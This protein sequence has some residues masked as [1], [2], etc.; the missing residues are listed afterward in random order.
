L[1]QDIDFSRIDE[2]NPKL[3][4]SKPNKEIVSTLQ[5]AYNISIHPKLGS[6]SE[7]TFSIPVQTEI[8]HE[9]VKNPDFEL[10]R[11]FY[12]VKYV[13]GDT[14]EW[15]LLD[16]PSNKADDSTLDRNIHCYSLPF[17]LSFRLLN[18]YESIAH[19]AEVVLTEILADTSWSINYI[20]SSFVNSYRTITADN[21]SKLD[22]LNQTA[23][24]F[25]AVIVYNTENRTISLYKSDDPLVMYN[26]GLMCSYGNLLKGIETNLD[27]TNFSTRFR[28]IGLNG[29]T[30]QGVN[31][32]SSEYLENYSYFM[33]GFLQDENGNVLSSSPYMSD[34]LCKAI[35]AYN[36]LV[37]THNGEYSTFLSNLTTAQTLLTTKNNELADLQTTM[38]E[39]TDTLDSL[40]GTTEDTTAIL[41][42]MHTQQALLDAKNAEIVVVNNSI[43]SINGQITVLLN[44]LSVENNFTPEQILERS[45]YFYDYTWTN[46]NIWDE[47]DLYT[48]AVIEFQKRLTP[49][50]L[51]TIDS[52]NF[53]EVLTEQANWKKLKLGTIINVYYELLDVNIQAQ[54]IEYTLNHGD[55]SLSL[56][57]ANVKEILNDDQKFVKDM[58]KSISTSNVVQINKDKWSTIDNIRLQLSDFLANAFS[59]YKQEIIAGTNE[60]VLVNRRGITVFDPS[61]PN[62]MLR[63]NHGNLLI[64]KDGGET[65]SLAINGNGVFAETI[66]GKL[67]VGEQL[68]IESAD[69]KLKILPS[70]IV[71]YDTDGVTEV[72]K[73]G[74]VSTAQDNSKRGL[75][76]KNHLGVT[77]LSEGIVQSDSIQMADNVDSTHKLSLKIYVPDDVLEIRSVQLAFSLEN[78]RTYETSTAGGGSSSTTSSSGGG[79]TQTSSSGGSS[80]PTSS[81][82]TFLGYMTDSS[83]PHPDDVASY[84]NHTHTVQIDGQYF[85]HNHTVSIGSHSHSVSFDPHQHNIYLPDHQHNLNFAIYEGSKA[86]LCDIFVN[87]VVVLNN[88][89]NTDQS[90][91]ELASFI[92]TSGWNTVEISSA[93][94][95]RINASLHIK[96]YVAL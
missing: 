75:K 84:I 70:G 21:Q 86:S 2:M 8:H 95:G 40:Q 76:L 64:S 33:E 12:L 69:G 23:I 41:A 94:L 44:L 83:S 82:K 35:I 1:L 45:Q 16:K 27:I 51:V 28:P 32:L 25:N 55:G 10:L 60:S 7:L 85:E 66:V 74:D 80:S 49:P 11:P 19:N 29:I 14:I 3:Y 88:H 90:N 15:F 36:T 77:V 26:M 42:Q 43:T 93:T 57:V 63:I 62:L 58:Y 56:L 39:I 79:G 31:P 54:I 50:I 72:I 4:L 9:F 47:N 13:C 30:I 34:D 92:T 24:A 61:S 22:I 87:G 89:Y 48:E 78:F 38:N 17:E 46:E 20:D 37:T 18:S 91:L 67:L 71:I 52:V 59:T 53:L 68:I 81:T 5:T 73:L 65:V 96:S 6:V